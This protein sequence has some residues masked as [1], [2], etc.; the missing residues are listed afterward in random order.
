MD[1]RTMDDACIYSQTGIIKL[2]KAKKP[3][4][5]NH[6]FILHFSFIIITSALICSS[7]NN[8]FIFQMDDGGDR[9]RIFFLLFRR[10]IYGGL[11]GGVERER[12]NGQH[13]RIDECN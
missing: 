13:I 3:D 5:H 6:N 10:Q 11:V 4:K 12:V 7:S 2:K 9:S 8:R 1:S